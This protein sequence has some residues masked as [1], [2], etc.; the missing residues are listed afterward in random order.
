MSINTREDGFPE[1][2][3]ERVFETRHVVPH[4][5]FWSDESM[6]LSVSSCKSLKLLAPTSMA[7]NLLWVSAVRHGNPCGGMK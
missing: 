7:R 1:K 5:S 4:T 2:H 3:R 6:L